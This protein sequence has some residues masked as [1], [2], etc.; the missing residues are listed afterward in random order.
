M[1]LRFV[2]RDGKKILQ[3]CEYREMFD[4]IPNEDGVTMRLVSFGGNYVWVDIPLCDEFT[5]E[6]IK[7]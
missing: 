3:Y 4:H 2:I 7:E 5:G 6:E 1:N